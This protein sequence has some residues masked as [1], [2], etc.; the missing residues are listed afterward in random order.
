MAHAKRLKSIHIGVQIAPNDPFWVQVNETVR[1]KL[2]NQIVYFDIDNHGI[3]LTNAQVEA[4]SEEILLNE[5]DAFICMILPQK[6][7]YSLLDRGLPVICLEHEDNI[8]HPLFTSVSGWY[9]AGVIIAQFMAQAMGGAGRLLCLTGLADDTDRI[10]FNQDRLNGLNH[11]LRN[12]PEIQVQVLESYWDYQ[13][14]YDQLIDQIQA[15]QITP[16]D[17]IL[18]LS[19]SLALAARSAGDTTG[20]FSE[21]TLLGGINWEPTALAEIVKGRMAATVNIRAEEF[22]GQAVELA[23]KATQREPLPRYFYFSPQL[24][25]RENVAEISVHKLDAISSIPS[26]LVGINRK[27]EEGRLK[28]YEITTS[29]NREMAVL[30]D[31]TELVQSITD[32][33]R[34]NY[35]YSRVYLY[36][37]DHDQQVF[38]LQNPDDGEPVTVALDDTGHMLGEMYSKAEPVF[39]ADARFS[40]RFPDDPVWQ[41]MRA[42]AVLP[43][44]FGDQL[45]GGL[46][47][48]SE[49]PRLELRT[50][51]LS[52]QQLANQLG[53]ALHNARLYEEAV[54]ARAAAETANQL[55]TRLLANVSHELRAPLNI[56][57]GYCQAILLN[58]DLYHADLPPALLCDLGHISNS[59]EHLI[60]LINDLLDVS[61]AEIGALDLFPETLAPDVLL[62]DVFSAMA[63]QHD[64]QRPVDWRLEIPD[65]LPIV[66]ADAVRLRQI[67]INLLS[68]ASKFTETGSITLG[69]AVEPPH[70]HIWV[71]DTGMGISEEQQARIFEPFVTG[72]PHDRRPQGIG[73]GLNIT[74]RLVTL[75]GGTLTC[76]SQPG[77]GS[78]FHVTLPL[79]NLADR[80]ATAAFGVPEREVMLVISANHMPSPFILDVCEQQ[81]LQYYPLQF[82]NDLEAVLDEVQP[83]AIAWDMANFA[84]SEWGTIQRIKEHPRLNK[85][86]FLVYRGEEA[87][88]QREGPTNILTKPLQYRSLYDYVA[89]L[90]PAAAQGPL[91]I[92]DDDPATRAAHRD[93]LASHF[94]GFEI[95]EARDG[96]EAIRLLEQV[97]PALILLDLM[98][99]EIDG[100]K[101]L[102]AVRANERTR[103]V[104]VVVISGKVLT[105][106][107]VKKLDYA[108]VIYQKKDL[109]TPEEAV[110]SLQRVFEEAEFLPQPTSIL[111]KQ[112]LAYLQIN[113]PYTI[114]RQDVADAVGTSESYLSR[115]FSQE[116]GLTLWEFLGRLRIQYAKELLL[117][118]SNAKTIAEIAFQV[119]YND[120]AYFCK[121]FKKYTG[122]SPQEYRKHDGQTSP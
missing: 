55:K 34:V 47:L 36:L 97:T 96:S 40:T 41:A 69:A 76:E 62:R 11:I 9:D 93:L 37:L 42:R 3:D 54:Q 84:P 7:I 83:G 10:D 59:G 44:R 119:G 32:L 14:A 61:R 24:V 92:V 81:G 45:L 29:I 33:I 17:A 121:V 118:Y 86:P 25:T 116:V 2:L 53:I 102:E 122:A 112:A 101:V 70:L 107:D 95:M 26:Q 58:P 52:L 82:V 103:L 78:T 56:I 1:Q 114:T 100:F 87:T 85:L 106:E 120:P 73:L 12:Y 5:L 94:S 22:A 19:D 63:E 4:L 30:T 109:L 111:V 51:L 115:I 39:V 49:R 104:P 28:Q 79:P 8:T 43:V 90:R 75:H 65:R 35:G 89:S 50:E 21:G 88:P 117:N 80:A 23:I 46:D 27:T 13:R 113:Y 77:A 71:R 6:L 67:L 68:N 91:L 15:G 57:L 16:P 48:Q 108:N 98:M 18:G 110:K 20:F 64:N 72:S 38:A 66:K 60:R 105:F 74:R 31:K 99:P